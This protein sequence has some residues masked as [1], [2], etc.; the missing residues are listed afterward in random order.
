MN[1]RA[2]P[3]DRAEVGGGRL[4]RK[5]AQSDEMSLLVLVGLAGGAHVP[6]REQIE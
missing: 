1:A 3:D 2:P 5:M 6:C 4:A